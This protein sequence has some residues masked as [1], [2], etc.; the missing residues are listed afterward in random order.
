[1]NAVSTCQLIVL[2]RW[3]APGRCKRRLALSLGAVAAARIQ[4]RLTGHTLMAAKQATREFGFELVLAVE[5]LGS[6]AARRWGQGL[7]A[8]RTLLQGQGGL[9]LRMQRQFR[10]AA[11][12]GATQV[13][14]IGSDLPQ[15][16]GGDLKAAFAALGRRE[17]VL[18]PA[19]DGGYWL[20]GL[21]RPDPELLA[22]IAWGGAQV[23]E[24]TLAAMARRGLE[25]ELLT[26]RGD[27]DW[28]SDLE[29]WR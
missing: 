9:G 15:L 18:G 26:T 13:V 16:E 19:H 14:L 27:L 2:A 10:R 7:G 17:G 20:I 5:G 3:P 21:R 1:M 23:L 6:R 4:T 29:P 11:R 8:D 12:E 25:P 22:G 24:Q 28:A